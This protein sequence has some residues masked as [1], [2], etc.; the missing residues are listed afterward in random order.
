VYDANQ[1]DK[2]VHLRYQASD[3]SFQFDKT[4]YY[5]GGLVTAMKLYVS[6][7]M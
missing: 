7:I 2:L 3:E 6:P 4:W 1:R 5:P